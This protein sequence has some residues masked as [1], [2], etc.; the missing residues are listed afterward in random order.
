M[1]KTVIVVEQTIDFEMFV[2]IDYDRLLCVSL[3]FECHQQSA[4]IK[5]FIQTL[6]DV[7]SIA[8]P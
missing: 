6:N 5:F 4:H 7:K 1:W 2:T 3:C 8:K